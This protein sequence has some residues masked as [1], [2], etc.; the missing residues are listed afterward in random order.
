[1][2]MRSTK[3][4]ERTT[5]MLM[6]IETEAAAKKARAGELTQA[7]I[8]KTF[9]EMMEKTIGEKL[10]VSSIADFFAEWLAS[11]A[12]TGKSASTVKRYRPILDGFVKFIG[13]KR[14]KA[15][16]GSVTTTEISRFRDKE[17]DDGKSPST[18]D[19]AVRVL[20]AVLTS[21]HRQGL[22]LQNPATAV[23]SLESVS[24]ERDPFTDEQVA[25]ML[26]HASPDWTGMILLGVHTGIRLND[27]A[28]LT[29][30]DVDI[31]KRTLTF[32]EQKTSRR[33][34]STDKRTQVYLHEDVIIWLGQQRRGV[35]RAP[36]FR[37]LTGHKSG[38][39]GGLSNMFNRLMDKAGI[40]VPLGDVK[41]GKGRQFRK[42]GFHSLRHT[43]VSRLASHEV[44]ADIRKAMAGHS[45]DEVHRRYVHQDVTAQ[46]NAV[47]KLPSFLAPIPPGK[48]NSA[49]E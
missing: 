4:M 32:L 1:M 9:G 19:F 7:V 21:A 24:E 46:A 35:A 45:S 20:Q 25:E 10:A 2:V 37:E 39:A 47:G 36:L 44:S 12:R 38:S 31:E 27:A 48:G 5:A 30:G 16:I 11:K 8:L 42:L 14:A 28:N 17:L 29:W 13:S 15:S 43:F 18:A 23:E 26:L 41:T 33:K 34:K 6:A 49:A 22:I 40:V 3:S